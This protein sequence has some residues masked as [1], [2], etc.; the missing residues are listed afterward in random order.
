MKSSVPMLRR[1][2]VMEGPLTIYT[3]S[4]QKDVLLSLFPLAH[5]VELDLSNVDELD[6]A[7]LQLLILIKRESFKDGSQ[8]VLSNPSAAVIE[9]LRLSGLDDY[10]AN[11]CFPVSA[12]A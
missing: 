1:I 10:F 12:G 11:P 2:Q 3:A 4:E 8:L 9:A 6:S 7:G 5:E